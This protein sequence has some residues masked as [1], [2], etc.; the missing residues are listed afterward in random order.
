MHLTIGRVKRATAT[1]AAAVVALV[2]LV[3]TPHVAHAGSPNTPSADCFDNQGG[4]AIEKQVIVPLPGGGA[5]LSLEVGT[6]GVQGALLPN[7]ENVHVGICFSDTTPGTPS[8]L[9][10]G[11][12]FVNSVQL[13]A[14]SPHPLLSSGCANDPNVVVQPQCSFGL[15]AVITPTIGACG[16]TCGAT[17]TVA[18]PVQVC[19]GLDV[20]VHPVGFQCPDGASGIA[21]TTGL[22]GT[23][24]LV[25]TSFGLSGGPGGSA[26]IVSTLWV[27][28]ISVPIILGV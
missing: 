25:I 7:L 22:S 23:T 2:G 16:L 18:V 26:G 27:D 21:T 20:G 13:G 4:E 5:T 15:D 6:G 14:G 17:V 1:G 9:A 11:I 8:N 19:A 28:G 3:T 24:G 10:G 12:I